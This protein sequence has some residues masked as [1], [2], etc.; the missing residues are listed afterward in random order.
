M[1]QFNYQAEAHRFS[2][3]EEQVADK[4]LVAYL[5]RTLE[6]PEAGALSNAFA[7]Q[8]M[9]QEVQRRI[10]LR[11]LEIIDFELGPARFRAVA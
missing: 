7:L 1:S 5:K 8:Q 10:E 11:A 2:L 3:E 4:R 9:R 6:G